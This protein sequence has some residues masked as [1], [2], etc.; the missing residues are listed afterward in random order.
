MRRLRLLDADLSTPFSLLATDPASSARRGT[1]SLPHGVVETPIF[2]PV[3]TQGSVKTLHPL[4][5]EQL[6]AQ[7][8]LGNTYHLWLRP[9]H[10]LIREMGATASPPG[11]S[12]FSPTRADS[13]F[14]PWPSSAR[15]PK[16]ACVFKTTLMD[17]K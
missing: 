12:P 2:M 10:E 15:S 1:L 6:G 13:K 3:G 14:G 8:I 11:K 7:I 9:G 4:E 5:L 16:R 17:R